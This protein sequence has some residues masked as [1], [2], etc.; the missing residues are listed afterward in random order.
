M[1]KTVI[2]RGRPAW[3]ARKGLAWVA[4]ECSP[5]CA[6][7]AGCHLRIELAVT[8]TE[9]QSYEFCALPDAKAAFGAMIGLPASE[10]GG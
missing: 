6:G 10:A 7:S 3:L 5:R 2:V 4:K 8:S 1:M 9:A